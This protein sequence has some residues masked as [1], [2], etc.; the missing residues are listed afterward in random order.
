MIASSLTGPKT[1]LSPLL[2]RLSPMAQTY[3]SGNDSLGEVADDR[4]LLDVWLVLSDPV[5]V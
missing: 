3:P 5:H 4:M 2:L 1:R